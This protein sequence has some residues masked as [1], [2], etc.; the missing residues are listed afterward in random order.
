MT[1]RPPRQ[2][3][4]DIP[5]EATYDI[6]SGIYIMR[7]LPLEVGKEFVLNIS[8]AG[9]IYQVPVRVTA[10]EMQKTVIGRVQCYR[11]EPEV[12]GPGRMIESEGS[13][14]IWISDDKRR[15]PV[16]GE[17]NS[18]IGKVEVKLK[19]AYTPKK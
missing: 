15:I 8:E 17:I 9:L 1:Q 18:R 16:R 13:L 19:K 12:F 7:H 6:S 11:L 3:A 5:E 4:S 2:I 14:K 10:R